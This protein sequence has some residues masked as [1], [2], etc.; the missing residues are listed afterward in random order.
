MTLEEAAAYALSKEAEP[1][2][3]A[4]PV[5]PEEPSAGQ[6]PVAL[7]PREQ[8]VAVLM[9]REFTNREIASKLML[10]EHTVATHVRN[11]LKKLEQHSRKEIAAWFT[12]QR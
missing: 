3:P 11:I 4:F 5:P 10:S 7:T 6:P 8:E 12:E 2:A 1:T 9:A